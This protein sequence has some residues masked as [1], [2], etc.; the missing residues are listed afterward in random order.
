MPSLL[1]ALL[2]IIVLAAIGTVI[3][4]MTGK[5]GGKQSKPGSLRK[6]RAQNRNQVLKESSKRL[7][8]NPKDAEAH[9]ALGSLAWE[10]QAWDQVVKHYELL[11]DLCGSN[12]D[13]DEFEINMRYGL[14]SLKLGKLDEAYKGLYI[15][16]TLKQSNFEVNFNLGIL[17]FQK[18]QYEKAVPLL[19]QAASQQPDNPQ[20]LRYLG[21]AYF[22][23]KNCKEALHV[24]RKT[25][26][27][28]PE[29]K[30]TL[31]AIAETYY[32]LG[33]NDQALRIFSHLRPDPQLGPSAALFAG[34]I[35][36][37][38]RQY[39][40][41]I[42]DFEIGLRHESA[43]IETVV[44]LKYRLAAA[45]LKQQ[46]IGRS[47]Q[48]LNEIQSIYPGYKDVPQQ[49]SR[50]QELNANRNL[51][52][53]MLGQ[54]SDF[55]T[56]CRKISMC[57]FPSAKVKI[58][59][60]AVQKNEYADILAEVETK[61]WQ[62]LVLFRY[63]RTNGQIGELILRDLYSRIRDIK[64]GK[65]YCITTGTFTDEA[66][67]FVEARLIDLIEKERLLKMLNTMDSGLIQPLVEE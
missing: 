6:K 2:A 52:V 48:I 34:T 3:V 44:E 47:V 36:M 26:D 37:S 39:K 61:K 59:D 16:R 30:E 58:V 33:N 62:D 29:D 14:A 7:A 65:G 56:L 11:I 66:K 57:F 21:H 40:N 1:P 51:Q 41:A 63:I 53:F 24:L 12:P 31:Y 22:K 46:E 64:A 35:N 15:A 19:K 13:L 45:Y 17:E 27:L 8:Q 9:L 43:K 32:E 50:Y 28:I 5:K 49:L 60:I 4:I 38:L 10:E 25:I 20:V 54:V 23:L 55:V 67:R 18:K 42:M